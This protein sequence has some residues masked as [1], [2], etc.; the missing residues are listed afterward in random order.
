MVIAQDPPAGE[1]VPANSRVRVEI[2][3]HSLFDARRYDTP[4]PP[5]PP[6]FNELVPAAPEPPDRSDAT[7]PWVS[8]DELAEAGHRTT[9]V[10]DTDAVDLESR[11][12]SL[13]GE[14]DVDYVEDPV[15]DEQHPAFDPE[16]GEILENELTAERAYFDEFDPYEYEPRWTRKQRNRMLLALGVLLLLAALLASSHLSGSGKTGKVAHKPT[17]VRANSPAKRFAAPTRVVTV[18]AA[19]VTTSQRHPRRQ[20]PTTTPSTV[21]PASAPAPAPVVSSS[22]PTNAEAPSLSAPSRPAGASDPLAASS[23]GGAPAYLS[24][25]GVA[26]PPPNGPTN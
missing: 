7:P 17:G 26:S 5:P 6:E 25:T 10:N 13:G 8:D 1:F 3:D 16:T 12:D 18:T 23:T 11:W 15:V 4:Q 20:S 14:P 9:D 22:S 2:G 19:T 21:V 24:P